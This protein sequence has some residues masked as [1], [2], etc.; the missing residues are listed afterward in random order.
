MNT[1]ELN[2]E[3]VW[4]TPKYTNEGEQP[5][6]IWVC[7]PLKIVAITRDDHNLNFGKLLKFSDYDGKEHYYPMPLELLARDGATYREYLLSS[8]LKISESKKGR[9]LLQRYIDS[10]NPKKRMRCVTKLGW[11][12]D[13]YVLPD[14]S[15]G[16]KL[17][18]EI[19]FQPISPPSSA[20]QESKGSLIEWQENIAKYCVDNSR[21]CFCVS[22]SFAAP[23]LHLLGE[24]NGG[25]NLR[26]PSS[27][28]KTTALKV[29]LSVYGGEKM[30]R[31]WRGTSNG[32]E[33]IADLHN[34]SLLCLD[35]LG[36]LDPKIAGEM[37]YLL[38][39][40]QGKQRARRVG[41]AR[42]QQS[43]RLLFLSTGE[44]GLPDLISQS[45]QKTRG[46]HEVRIVDIPAFTGK[47]GVFEYLHDCTSGDELSRKLCANSALY[48]GTAGRAF[49]HQLIDDISGHTN[50]IKQFMESFK[51]DNAP[52]GADGQVLRVLNRF[53]LIA[54]AGT[55]ATKLGITA[56]P[57]QDAAWAA[58]E[59]F[60][61]W[62]IARGGVSAQE[63]KELLRQVRH[64]F[65]QH[66]EARFTLIGGNDALKTINRSG[67]RQ[68]IKDC[69]YYFVFPESFRQ[70]VCSG[71]DPQMAIQV[72]REKKW[73]IP[74]SDGKNTRS[75]RLPCSSQ[76]M[77]CYRLDGHKLFSD[78]I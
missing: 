7:S 33:A 11:Y 21:L 26:G 12:K 40:G 54:A 24:E 47:Y 1:F 32:F 73:L 38:V 78:D 35:E 51:K 30:L 25:V 74:G 65:E 70:E 62:L 43:W 44:I 14:E 3:G 15:I 19:V 42:P 36:K 20:S 48:H 22:T 71:F 77:R 55:L 34:D 4:Y 2:T 76:N 67:F 49:L 37:A 29:A 69:E 16:Q 50:F 27:G 66:G 46:G 72:L 75:E 10:S 53:A 64:Y 63:S 60:N 39:N 31:S 68:T 6:P 8:G 45:G 28:G 41:S 56:W 13:T 52:F 17:D 18:E 57:I 59:C 23:L 58:K 5:D 9:E 61:A